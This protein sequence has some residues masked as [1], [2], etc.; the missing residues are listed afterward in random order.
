MSRVE[1]EMSFKGV[2]KDGSVVFEEEVS[3][4]EG[5]PVLITVRTETAG[6]PQT[7]LRA[8]AQPPHVGDEDVAALLHE[9]AGGRRPVQFGTPLD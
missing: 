2:V 7:V 6:S 3:L 5:T 9:I 8:M 4:P 1:D